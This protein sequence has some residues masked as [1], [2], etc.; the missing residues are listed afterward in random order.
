VR[1]DSVELTYHELALGSGFEVG[2][3]T[4]L[5]AMSRRS[6]ERHFKTRFAVGPQQWL[7]EYRLVLA[8]QRARPDQSVKELAASCLFRYPSN[9]CRAFKQRFG[10]APGHAQRG[11]PLS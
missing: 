10:V 8:L 5:V 9:F 2:R 4:E 6:L 11:A 3:A 1:A 7:T